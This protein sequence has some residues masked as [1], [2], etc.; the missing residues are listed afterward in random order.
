MLFPLLDMAMEVYNESSSFDD[1]GVK[2]YE[3]YI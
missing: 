1:I 3:K 2:Q